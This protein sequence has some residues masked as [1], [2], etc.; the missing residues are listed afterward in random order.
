MADKNFKNSSPTPSS[1][2]PAPATPAAPVLQHAF[3]KEDWLAAAA[4]FLISFVAFCFFMSPSITLQDSGELVTGAYNFGVPHPPGYPLWAFMGW[5][6]RHVVPFGNPAWQICL[7]SVLTGALTVGL[8]TLFMT[9]STL[10][11]LRSLPWSSGMEEELR[12]W[13]SLTVGAS[14][15]LLFGFNR[16]VWL[17]ACVPEMRVL[18]VF[19]FTL[20]TF[21][22]FGWVMRAE[23]RGFLYAALLVYGLG[24]SN[25]QTV[26]VIGAALLVGV[27]LRGWWSEDAAGTPK[28]DLSAFCEVLVAFLFGWLAAVLL[29]AWLQAGES[30]SLD[31]QKVKAMILF[32]PE[33]SASFLML[34]A[35]GGGI[36]LLVFGAAQGWLKW[37]RALT[38]AGL[39]LL[40][41]G[42]YIYMPIASATNPPMNWGYAA[43]KQ[44][45]L[46]AIT[47]GQYQKLELAKVLGS[48]FG[49]QVSLQVQAL[50]N[51]YSLPLVL[52]GLVSAAALIVGWKQLHARSRMWLSYIWAA[53]LVT[54]IGLLIMIN[55][56]LDKQQQEINIKF[57][58][59]AHG[60]Y[61]VLIGYGLAITIAGILARWQQISTTAVRFAC[62]MLLALPAISFS[63]N[64]SAC[65]QRGHDFGY[66]FGYRMFYPGGGYPPM[67]KNA[68]LYGG[69]DPGRFVPTYMIFCESFAKPENRFR[70][71]HFDAAGGSQFD[72]RD[73]YIITQNALA[74]STYM[75]Y[76]RDHY[77]YERPDWNNAATITNWPAWRQSMFGWA[78]N[79][80]DRANMYP[81][82]PIWIPNEGDIQRA[83]QEYV[84]SL[85]TRQAGPDEQVE[86]VNGRVSVRG[87]AG[88]MN[89]NGILTRWIFERNKDK[90]AFY[91]EESYVIPWMY[92]YLEPAGIILKINHDPLPP[93]ETDP[94]R[95]QQII[96]R[97][98]AYWNQLVQEFKARPEFHRDSDAQKTF[99]KLRSA[100]GGLYANRRLALEAEYAYRQARDLCPESPEANFRLAQLYMELN[101]PD[102]AIKV[103]EELQALDPL[104]NKIEQ[105]IEQIRM[106]KQARTDIGRLETA[107]LAAPTDVR[108]LLQLAQAYGRAGFP[109]RIPVLCDSFLSLSNLAAS[110]M[111]QVAQLYLSVGQADRAVNALNLILSRYPE[112]SQSYYALAIIRGAMGQTEDALNALARAVQITPALRDQ[113]RNDARLNPLRNHPR[114]QQLVGVTSFMPF[115]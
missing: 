94:A 73:V 51:Q 71:S 28:R 12:H 58:A 97:D 115:Q 66:Q 35:G 70:D 8:M 88:V 10:M 19:F 27:L 105:A 63:R 15:S 46:H 17:W 41:V 113:A 13:I 59:P 68:V 110:D 3:H 45:F 93:P 1:S 106:I 14:V 37:P 102:D 57:F 6:W 42:F 114:F 9:R 92:P 25:H 107:R 76:I 47:R 91:V 103:L 111:I 20:I 18:N 2:T 39:F 77:A 31:G 64:L 109:D 65:D 84:Q 81:K 40:G 52:L 54:L 21:L 16:G 98:K 86:I 32:G 101:R 61:A 23:K 33:L 36:F 83:F 4:T 82:Q 100:I 44:G 55:P 78:W 89:I 75:S 11:L 72:R 5:V 62:I 79:A 34:L 49:L 30:G 60:F 90:H 43:T 112:D 85:K 67:E 53:F 96:A 7:M 22:F 69:T 48:D 95:W 38:C 24:I 56:G 108:L 104:N 26:S 87:V 29:F 99:S 50:V 80:L 74:D